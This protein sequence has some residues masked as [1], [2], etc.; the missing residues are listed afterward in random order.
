[1][2]NDMGYRVAGWFVAI[3]VGLGGTLFLLG[4]WLF[5]GTSHEALPL[6]AKT[7]AVVCAAVGLWF[8]LVSLL[9]GAEDVRKVMAP[10]E[11]G[12][13]VFF[14]WPCMLYHGSAAL[15]RRVKRAGDEG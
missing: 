13:T 8:A 4:P 14:L 9:T 5:G 1:M 6:W 10:F 15:W 11:G 2:E 7:G 3:L 12:E